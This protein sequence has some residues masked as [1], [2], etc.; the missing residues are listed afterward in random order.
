VI[1]ALEKICQDDEEF[2]K[3][4]LPIEEG[5]TYDELFHVEG[6]SNEEAFKDNFDKRYKASLVKFFIK[7][8]KSIRK[9]TVKGWLSLKFLRTMLKSELRVYRNLRRDYRKSKYL[10]EKAGLNLCV[11]HMMDMQGAFNAPEGVNKKPYYPFHKSQIERMGKLIQSSN[12]RIVGFTAF[13]PLHTVKEQKGIL[14]YALKMGNRGVKFYPPMGYRAAKNGDMKVQKHVDAFFYFCVEEDVP[15]FAHCTPE[16]FQARRF[17]GLNSDPDYWREALVKLENLG[18][19]LTLCLGHAGG[20][21]VDIEE[22]EKGKKRYP[23][24]FDNDDD[25][26][27]PY[28]YARKV[29]ELCEDFENVYC[30]VGYLTEVL[31]NKDKTEEIFIPRLKDLLLNGTP[32]PGKKKCKLGDKIMYGTD[33]HMRDVVGHRT[34]KYLNRFKEIFN[35]DENW[36]TYADRFFYLNSLK[37]LKLDKYISHHVKENPA[38]LS[39][40]AIKHLE[41]LHKLTKV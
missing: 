30:E 20:G 28:C 17:S 33:W 34:A 15:V 4:H 37:Y 7:L 9:S 27:S 13:N 39:D 6:K 5:M 24:W 12:G 11:H 26:K 10:N 35:R 2:T 22:P 32:R 40:E 1:T 18:G 31:D 23:G 8:A 19:K 3:K 25:W 41:G 16:G 21:G 36:E 29:V 14:I 38:F